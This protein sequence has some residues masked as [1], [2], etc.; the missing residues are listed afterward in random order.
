MLGDV[1]YAKKDH[2][3]QLLGGEHQIVY[4]ATLPY[5]VPVIDEYQILSLSGD[6]VV[7]SSNNTITLSEG[8]AAADK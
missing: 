2:N 3:K 5:D 6:H 7:A 1:N 8:N 4:F